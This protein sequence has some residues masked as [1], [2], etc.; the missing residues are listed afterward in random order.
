MNN[1]AKSVFTAG[2][3]LLGSLLA[4]T[5]AS[6]STNEAVSANSMPPAEYR[7]HSGDVIQV[8]IYGEDDLASKARL[9]ESGTVILPLL[10]ALELGGM[11]VSQAKD[12]ICD[13]YKKDYLVN[14]VVTVSILEYGTSKVSVLGQVRNPGIFQFPSNERLNLLQAIALAGGYTTIGEPSRVT[15]KRTVNGQSAIIRLDAQAM[16]GKEKTAI[17]EV[18][19]DDVISVGETIF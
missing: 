6:A 16:A 19:P 1:H 17:V 2:L 4:P 10:S 7:L 18:H 14:P 12:C 5:A 8:Q 9:N 11:T 3:C 15:I 13:A